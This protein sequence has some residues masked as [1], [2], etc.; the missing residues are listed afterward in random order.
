[1]LSLRFSA[2]ARILLISTLA[3]LSLGA[4]PAAPL[5][6][7]RTVT[8][9]G[10]RL[11]VNGALFE[12]EGVAYQPYKIGSNLPD[13]TAPQHDLPKISALGANTIRTYNAAIWKD[14]FGTVYTF[15]DWADQLLPLAETNGLMVIVGM[16]PN[17]LPDVDWN[18]ATLR[19]TWSTN[20][21]DMILRFKDYPAVLMWSLGNEQIHSLPANQKQAFVN[22]IEQE[23]QWAHTNDPN[24]PVM[25]ADYETSA[26]DWVR[27][28]IPSMDVYA[29]Q[30]YVYPSLANYTQ[31][32]QSAQ[33][34]GKPIFFSEWGSDYWDRK[35]AS[36]QHQIRAT[37]DRLIFRAAT[38][39]GTPSA[40]GYIGHSLFEFDND[41]HKVQSWSGLD[42]GGYAG[43]QLICG[44]FDCRDD[45][46]FW[47][48][49]AAV[50]D[51]QAANRQIFPISYNNI[52]DLYVNG[53]G[54]DTTPPSQ[55]TGL[56]VTGS[57]NYNVNLSWTA[58]GAADL[59]FYLVYRGTTAGFSL[60]K[61]DNPGYIR[62]WTML[63][64]V[65]AGTTTFVDNNVNGFGPVP[66]KSYYYRVV[67]VDKS[68][69][70]GAASSEVSGA[71]TG[72]QPNPATTM[73]A[74]Q[75]KL[76]LKECFQI[77]DIDRVSCIVSKYKMPTSFYSSVKVTDLNNN[78]VAGALV[79]AK[80]YDAGGVARYTISATTDANGYAWLTK[81]PMSGQFTKGQSYF[82]V[83]AITKTGMSADLNLG[84]GVETRWW[85]E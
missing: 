85:A 65:P 57:G 64:P 75:A 29:I 36:A 84:Y 54:S 66:G 40:S 79:T 23:V 72:A 37:W 42:W 38:D 16:W 68:G 32:V 27:D 44:T 7:A 56:T 48:I 58:S 61:P 78:P 52:Q 55:M 12:I 34:V 17:T 70:E 71:T 69:N 47:G 62:T 82:R 11:Y 33:T 15:R 22:W 20:W 21:H 28:Y 46:E 3:L 26:K 51:G 13:P 18:N 49:T 6:L 80:I 4:A 53:L 83:T 19:Q 74:F 81:A 60:T 25:Y 1:M 9:S 24:H 45:Q 5:K 76:L 8:L 39:S 35:S 10:G 31:T 2:L 30:S 14:S 77:K 50:A 59:S 73:V 41:Q 63:S 43:G 67:A